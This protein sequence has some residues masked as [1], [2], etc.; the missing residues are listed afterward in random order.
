[1]QFM[2]GPL[3]GERETPWRRNKGTGVLRQCGPEVPSTNHAD[4]DAGQRAKQNVAVH[5]R[6]VDIGAS[7]LTDSFISMERWGTE[8]DV[9]PPWA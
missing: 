7:M 5:E 4:D 2:G 6:H 3:L 1:M 9:P 8:G